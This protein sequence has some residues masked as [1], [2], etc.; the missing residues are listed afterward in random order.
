MDDAG[1]TRS[2][3]AVGKTNLAL[4][5]AKKRT[6]TPARTLQPSGALRI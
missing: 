4:R 1:A 2:R 5:S 6:L 3:L